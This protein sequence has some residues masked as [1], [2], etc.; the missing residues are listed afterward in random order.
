MWRSH[1][2]APGVLIVETNG[3]TVV[4]EPTT[5]VVL[6]TGSVTGTAYT[7]TVVSLAA[8]NQSVGSKVSTT[9]PQLLLSVV[10]WISGSA[11][12]RTA[13]ISVIGTTLAA[14]ASGTSRSTV[15]RSV[16]G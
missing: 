4:V 9:S 2:D 7:A 6:G 5:V 11:N 13:I 8:P 10:P 14:A 3:S 15:S 12:F 1:D 16:H